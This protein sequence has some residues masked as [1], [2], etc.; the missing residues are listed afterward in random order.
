M[1]NFA[2]I[3]AGGTGTRAG[4]DLPKQFQK[5]GGR[6]LFWRSVDA[7][8]DFDPHCSIIL[9][10]HPYF[11]E[12][13]DAVFGDEEKEEEISVFKTEGGATRI[14]SV[15]KGLE[16]V[17]SLPDFT[18]DSVVFIHDSA[19]PNVSPQ[20]IGR[21]A[22]TV[23]A[24]VG[25]V[26]AVPLSDSIRQL[27]GEGSRAVDRSEYV[28]VQTPQ[29]FLAGDIIEAYKA[30]K[31]EDGLTDDASVAERAGIHIDLYEGDPSN[32]KITHPSDFKL[33]I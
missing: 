18:E 12:N 5:V 1:K 29:V 8:R 10:V 24:R 23:N 21:G 20:L 7:F 26:P 22:A 15:R 25:A 30:V 27:T 17:A 11:L 33:V 31:S 6:R 19:R 3:L 16:F 32:I 28:A 14:E 2:L 9:V 4:G 13:W